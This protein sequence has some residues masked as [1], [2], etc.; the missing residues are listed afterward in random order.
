MK[1]DKR[2]EEED[3]PNPLASY[4]P[5]RIIKPV[6]KQRFRGWEVV[7]EAK[8]EVMSPCRHDWF[9]ERGR[10]CRGKHGGRGMDGW[11]RKRRKVGREIGMGGG[12]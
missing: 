3:E 12:K 1:G 11:S 4:G 8:I 2:E 6:G 10:W 9:G 7:A 5:G